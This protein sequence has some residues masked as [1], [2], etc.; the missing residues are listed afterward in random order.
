MNIVSLAADIYKWTLHCRLNSLS[1]WKAFLCLVARSSALVFRM[2][3]LLFVFILDCSV[4]IASCSSFHYMALFCMSLLT[5]LESLNLCS[6]G[7]FRI[8]I[9]WK[10][11]KSSV[12]LWIVLSRFYRGWCQNSC[13][14]TSS[15]ILHDHPILIGYLCTLMFTLI[16][17]YICTP[18]FHILVIN[19]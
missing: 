6:R 8:I 3:L 17:I 19:K 11:H 13:L 7:H 9:S 14:F 15:L 12:S 16:L 18:L 10:T 1:S 4:F 2:K 5:N